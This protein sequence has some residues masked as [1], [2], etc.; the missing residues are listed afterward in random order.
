MP[1]VAARMASQV[2]RRTVSW[3]NS[4]AISAAKKGAA[5]ISTRVF[6]TVVVSTAN[7]KLKELSEKRPAKTSPG[8]PMAAN[9]ARICPL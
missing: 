2:R 4:R 9:L 7:T 6:A 5:L 8:Q 1:A 3:R